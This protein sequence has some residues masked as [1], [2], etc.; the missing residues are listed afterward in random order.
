MAAAHLE[1]QGQPDREGCPLQERLPE[2]S[3]RRALSAERLW[4]E[5]GK[6]FLASIPPPSFLQ[7]EFFTDSHLRPLLPAVRF[8]QAS[9]ERER[10]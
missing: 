3:A 4:E 8:L 10:W 7:S 1:S 2:R 5:A 9:E 6:R